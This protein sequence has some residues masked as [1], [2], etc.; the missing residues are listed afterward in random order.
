MKV[1]K[2]KI[3]KKIVHNRE[4]TKISEKK[5]QTSRRRS[6]QDIYKDI[7]YHDEDE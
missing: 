2:Q 3:Q 7:E 6:K 4:M 5:R 1:K